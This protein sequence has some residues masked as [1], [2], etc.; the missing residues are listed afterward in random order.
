MHALKTKRLLL[1]PLA[2]VHQNAFTALMKDPEVV[3]W[4]FD[5]PTEAE[6]QEQFSARLSTQGEPA[7]GWLSFAVLCRKSGDFLGI[8]GYRLPDA[9]VGF[10][11]RRENHGRGIATESLKALQGYAHSTGLEKLRARVTDGN[12]ASSR[13]LEKC[14]FSFV[15]SI[16]TG[17]RIAGVTYDDLLFEYPRV[18]W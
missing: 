13:V 8:I 14:G 7:G 11:F 3:R 18:G 10:L 1:E 4:C 17:V 9:E 12:T 5:L 16:G 6:I 15:R 2:E